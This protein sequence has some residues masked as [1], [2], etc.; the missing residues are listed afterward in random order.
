MGRYVISDHHFG[1][2]NIIDYCDRPFS[3]VGEMNT[4]LLDRYYETVESEDILIHLGD[5]AMD[6]QNGRETVEYFQRLDGDVLLRGN[7]DVGLDP[8]DAPFPVLGSCIVEHDDY[9][10]YC[11][12]RPADIPDEWEGWALHGHIH[13]NDTETYPFVAYDDRRVNVSSEL[14]NYRPITLETVTSVLDTCAPGIRLRDVDTAREY[15]QS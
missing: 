8:D 1:H 10:F 11:T 13:N 7:H 9:R 3:S 15:V 6:M 4:E 14:L 12:H 5:V 2:A